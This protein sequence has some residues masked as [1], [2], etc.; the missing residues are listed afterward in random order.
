MQGQDM[1]NSKQT[2]VAGRKD[3]GEEERGPEKDGGRH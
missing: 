3:E 2:T 1:K